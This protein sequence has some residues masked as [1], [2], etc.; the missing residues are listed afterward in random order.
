MIAIIG[1][2]SAAVL[3]AASFLLSSR[4]GRLIG[5]ASTA[6]WML[7]AG[8]VVTTPLALVSGP[9]P[10]LTPELLAW[11]AGS[12]VG[13]VAGVLMAYQGIRIGKVD[14]VTA[15]ASTEGVIA[16]VL[17]IVAGERLTLPVALTLGAIAV[18]IA[19]VALAPDAAEP[20]PT[21]VAAPAGGGAT[22]AT[23]APYGIADRAPG[24]HPRFTPDQRAALFGAAAAVCFGISMYSTAKVGAS[25][26]PIWAVLPSR[27]V[28]VVGVLIPL[29]LLGRLR[30]TRSAVPLVVLIGVADVFGNVAYVIGA[31]Q[32][33]AIS[34]VLA[35]QYA[36]VA[37]AAA[38]FVF[39]ERLSLHQRSGVVAIA[40]GVAVLTLVRG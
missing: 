27:L 25:M 7:L 29:A 24:S 18:G 10:V 8:L 12:G 30:L 15:L 5:A 2:L 9:L 14:A 36:A 21:T 33:I 1:G 38:F 28:G 22:G 31:S 26:T 16:A 20:V 4:S 11:M 3:W 17:A 23:G 40:V 19:M 32:S 34:A 39:H 35:S 13:G 6:G 37:A